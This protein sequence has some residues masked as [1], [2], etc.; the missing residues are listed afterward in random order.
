MRYAFLS[1]IV[2]TCTSVSFA[3]WL[4]L[5]SQF[6][7]DVSSGQRVAQYAPIV[8]PPVPYVSNFRSSGYTNTR[9][10]LN[11]GPSADNYHRVEKWGDQVRPYGEWRF[12]FRPFST[13]YP[14][15][16]APYAGLNISNG[17]FGGGG[18][19]GSGVNGGFGRGAGFGGNPGYQ[20]GLPRGGYIGR[21]S[22][23]GSPTSGAAPL[24]L[25]PGR[26]VAP[27]GFGQNFGTLPTPNPIPPYVDGHHP[28]YRN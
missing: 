23:P 17:G 11:F 24:F 15:W 7:H 1:L 18:F 12:P 5:P 19:A 14:N 26:G 3:D 10:S 13:P 21:P 28:T 6:S 20:P 27:S 2:F 22:Q 25:A 8:G 9:S 4:T 16:G